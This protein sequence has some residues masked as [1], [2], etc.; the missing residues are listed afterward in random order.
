[1]NEQLIVILQNN[2]TR[3][4]NIYS[5]Y[6]NPYSPSISGNSSTYH[7]QAISYNTKE[8]VIRPIQYKGNFVLLQRQ[9]TC[10]SQYTPF[11]IVY[12]FLSFVVAQIRPP[13]QKYLPT[14]PMTDL[15]THSTPSTS[16]TFNYDT[17]P[18]SYDEVRSQACRGS[19]PLEHVPHH[20]TG[21]FD[22]L[23]YLRP[24][25]GNF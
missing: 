18:P 14:A 6:S 16:T 19:E 3:E 25:S 24:L 21:K 8:Q 20:S 10:F 4:R 17:P 13:S 22:Q 2:G 5:I 23:K 9:S 15:S 11:S 12:Y 7:N 1:M